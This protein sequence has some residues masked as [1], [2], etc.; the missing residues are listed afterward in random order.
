MGW[1]HV[2]PADIHCQELAEA[3][4]LAG[5]SN[6]KAGKALRRT[7]VAGHR[8]RTVAAEAAHAEDTAAAAS[9]VEAGAEAD[10]C[11]ERADVAKS[12]TAEGSR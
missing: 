3:G 11:H 8:S 1:R 5:S 2:A 7:A 4:L 9:R 6:P 12:Q 10:S